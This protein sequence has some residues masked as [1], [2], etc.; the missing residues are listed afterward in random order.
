MGK[1]D[2]AKR[3]L[4][5]HF[6]MSEVLSYG[7][8]PI[9]SFHDIFFDSKRAWSDTQYNEGVIVKDAMGKPIVDMPITQSCIINLHR[10]QLFGGH[11]KEGGIGGGL[12]ILFGDDHQLLPQSL[13]N[14]ILTNPDGDGESGNNPANPEG[15]FATYRNQITLFL[16]EYV[17]P[18]YT[19]NPRGLGN[20]RHIDDPVNPLPHALRVAAPSYT[21]LADV[22]AMGIKGKDLFIPNTHAGFFKQT[23][24]A[25]LRD[26]HIEG[27][28]Y[29][30]RDYPYSQIPRPPDNPDDPAT[31][32]CDANP[33]YQIY[34]ALT[35]KDFG[36]AM[37]HSNIN[38]ESFVEAAKTLYEE[39][40]IAVQGDMIH[41]GFGLSMKFTDTVAIKEIVEEIRGHINAVIYED[42]RTGLTNIRLMRASDYDPN[43]QTLPRADH[44]N[45]EVLSFTRKREELPNQ[46][47]ILFTNPATAEEDSVIVQ[48]NSAIASEAGVIPVS[49][50]FYGV[51]SAQKAQELGERDLRAAAI[52]LAGIDIMLF[53]EFWDINP[54]DV[55]RVIS[56]ED[57]TSDIL[58]RVV[59]VE[60]AAD[61]M[62]GIKATLIEDIFARDL[63][64]VYSP[65]ATLFFD[66]SIAPVPAE[67]V[68]A[69]TLP[70]PIEQRT[71]IHEAGGEIAHIGVLASSYEY[72]TYTH[73]IAQTGLSIAGN[74]EIRELPTAQ[75][76]AKGMLAEDLAAAVESTI[77]AFADLSNGHAPAVDSILLIGTPQSFDESGNAMNTNTD[78]TDEL[79]VV[80]Q[81]LDDG[82]L[83]IWR[84]LWDTIPRD[85]PAGSSVWV[86]PRRSRFFDTDGVPIGIEEMF[87][88]LTINGVGI[89]DY[90]DPALRDWTHQPSARAFL[91][92][93]P[94]NVAFSFRDSNGN[95]S[96]YTQFPK[97]GIFDRTG[98]V[99]YNLRV[100]T[101]TR[102]RT[103][104]DGVANKWDAGYVRGED[105]QFTR[106]EIIVN[107][108]VVDTIDNDATGFVQTVFV[109]EASMKDSNG[110]PFPRFKFRVSSVIKEGNN[111]V[112]TSLQ[113]YEITIEDSSQADWGKKWGKGFGGPRQ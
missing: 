13:I 81:V 31:G 97:N 91:P 52:P 42:A 106:V 57:Q 67:G 83:L 5:P 66:P 10:P 80:K 84:G 76:I 19:Y 46:F 16:H 94:A 100:H 58:M 53:R 4:I 82:R 99:N 72:G 28:R 75:I 8:G 33:A 69:I 105:N 107:N 22:I 88:V 41:K 96:P 112:L 85:W 30:L 87:R 11:E 70:Y 32:V 60:D 92:F 62:G 77:P 14:K 78:A 61:G 86:L 104:E 6:H 34:E 48:D 15:D 35:D 64:P 27:S 43:D 2:S 51:H 36:G 63:P 49:Q 47:N 23:N 103:T 95:S 37:S 9:D 21:M 110:V 7:V 65:P 59:A 102:N 26:I 68:K 93:R 25:Y 1:S 3:P 89:L 55:I 45:S 40:G 24:S 111:V 17:R 108:V 71:G 29:P 39:G 73:K 109:P 74:D 44:N 18:E 50:N 56:P 12:T 38:F 54:G 113:N 20:F 90:N 79:C 101:N 98:L